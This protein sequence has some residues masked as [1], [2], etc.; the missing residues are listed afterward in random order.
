MPVGKWLG[1]CVTIWGVATACTAAATNFQ[2]L[3]AARIFLGL[4][5]AA[6]A[7]SLMIAS[8]QWYTRSE[9]FSRYSFWYCGVGLGQ[10]LG[11]VLSFG[12][13]QV[14]DAALSGWRIM[15]LT[16]GALTI[17]VGVVTLL[18]LPDSPMAAR[19]LTDREKAAIL[20]H[21]AANQTGVVNRSFTPHHL[22]EMLRDVQLWLMVLLTLVV[23]ACL[24]DPSPSKCRR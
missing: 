10:I 12:F 5:E 6:I 21:V 23:R 18:F 4:F 24:S 3:L 16:L 17:L 13:Q 9:Q 22:L 8:S 11:G 2:S 19:F 15:F 20:H 1:S 14:T 7:P